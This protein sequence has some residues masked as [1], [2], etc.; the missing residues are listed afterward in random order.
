MN[1]SR[2][3]SLCTIRRLLEMTESRGCTKAE[4]AVA[5]AKAF[6]L[7]DAHG[8]SLKE[9]VSQPST[10]PPS[11]ASSRPTPTPHGP[12][13]GGATKTRSAGYRKASF[14]QIV[15]F[16]VF[17]VVFVTIEVSLT[18]P[19]AKLG[20][21]PIANPAAYFASPSPAP[22]IT[23]QQRLRNGRWRKFTVS[24]GKMVGTPKIG[25]A[26]WPNTPIWQ[27]SLTR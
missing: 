7:M 25:K 6:A 9:L 19:G 17:A 22:E 3:R 18:T 4:A 5:R 16:L 8:I 2:E 12:W 1:Q 13:S 26:P 23:Y 14:A 21:R 11:P 27:E 15:G 24:G 10:P 20:N